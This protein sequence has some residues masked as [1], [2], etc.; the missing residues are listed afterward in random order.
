MRIG[1]RLL[2]NSVL[3][4]SFSVIAT[5]LVIGGV[6]YNYGKNIL[7]D[8]AKD[9]L[10][11]VRDLKED[12]IK[13]YFNNV[14]NQA[15][16]FSH[17]LT[18][19]NAMT[20]LDQGF[21]KYASE[22]S[23][24]GTT[25]YRDEVIKHYLNEFSKDYADS[26]GGLAYDATKYLN[27]SNETTFALQYNYI[28]NNPYGID[29][30]SKLDSVNDGSAYSKDHKKYHEMIKEFKEL[31]NFEDIFLVDFTTS[32]ID[33][34]YA[35]TALGAVF[36]RANNATGAQSA[37]VS[38][39]EAYAP[40]ND[41]QAAFVATNIYNE[42]KK[43]G[44]LIFQLNIDAINDI[45][46]SSKDWENVG[47]GKTGETYLV[48]N[49][50]QMMTMSR[51][52]VENPEEYLDQMQR[53]GLNKDVITRMRGKKNNMG[54]QEI[55]SV[56]VIQAIN[57]E[58]GFGVY[59][60]Y[61]NKE[62]LGA[63]EPLNISGVNWGII[64]EIDKDEAFA[65]VHEL[66]KK[67]IVTLTIVMILIIF[68]AVIV[69]IG[70][71]RQISIPIEK[72][73]SA[74]RILSKTQDLTKRME[75]TD[76][77]EIGDMANSIN[78]LIESFQRTTQETILSTQRVHTAAHKLM[79]LADDIDN[80]EASHKFEDNFELVHEKTAAIK[81]AGDSLEELSER[82]QVLSRQFKVF[83]AENERTS[84]W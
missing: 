15:I 1:L 49:N 73:S 42:D 38:N 51:F 43:I 83:E 52:F 25:K 57:G 72:L 14:E 39:F 2:T 48:D 5:T 31:Y 21:R 59:K 75:Y 61:R 41:D 34:P 80:R 70:L 28:F 4:A 6:S 40:S 29:K 22:V 33:G 13:R 44:V 45:M 84:G 53:L 12:S 30:E 82:L 56:A 16:S 71:A 36:R 24:K 74:I 63:Y 65:P 47:L 55:K 54:L 9:R 17:N 3:I 79:S 32:L 18:I 66:A 26:N 76:D 46:T 64:C 23:A 27:L 69:G 60:D 58:S 35:N 7:E 8:Q 81:D 37:V 77:D 50:E 11:L 67:I 62:V 10:L 78:H 20:D 68:F 19:V